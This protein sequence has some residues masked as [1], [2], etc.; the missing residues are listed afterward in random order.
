MMV[1]VDL[2]HS[3][4]I[5]TSVHLFMCSDGIEAWHKEAST[6]VHPT[7]RG[8]SRFGGLVRY[9]SDM[10]GNQDEHHHGDGSS[11][12]HDESGHD[13]S[14]WGRVRHG[15]GHFVGHDHDHGPTAAL[16]DTGAE[17]IRATKVSLVTVCSQDA[18]ALFAVGD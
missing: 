8:A 16:L 17:G 6:C 5:C 3:A 15:V 11:D 13:E 9:D 2:R 7:S 1:F 18:G 10:A 4:I 14:W 12:H